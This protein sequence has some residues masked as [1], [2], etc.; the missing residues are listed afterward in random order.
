MI[1]I[2][3][4]SKGL[5]YSTHQI[6]IDDKERAIKCIESV[7]QMYDYSLNSLDVYLLIR[8]LGF[9]AVD[10]FIIR[11]VSEE[12]I[13]VYDSEHI[14]LIDI[15]E[16]LAL[17]ELD[18]DEE[19]LKRIASDLYEYTFS[20]SLMPGEGIYDGQK[21][22]LPHKHSTYLEF[23]IA[24]YFIRKVEEYT[25]DDSID[26]FDTM[27]TSMSNHF[28]VSYMEDNYVFQEKLLKFI[29]DKF[30]LFDVQQKS[31]A[32][33]WL[34]RITYKNLTNEAILFLTKEFTKY[35]LLVKGNN[36]NTQENLD[37]H[38]MFRSICAGLLY[39]GQANYMDE[40]LCIVITNDIANSL[41]R[42][43]TIEYY[44]DSYQMAAHDVYY[45]DTDLSAGET[46]IRVLNSKLENALNS[47]SGEFVEA[48]LVT[49]LTLI[50]A[51]IQNVHTALKYDV[52]SY[53]QKALGFVKMYQ[54]RPQNV[55]SGKLLG[56]FESVREDIELYLNTEKFDIGSVIYRQYNCLKFVK[57]KQWVSK[58]I[59]DPESVTEHT[60]SSW[61]LAAF[62]L[63][64][65]DN[66][67]G[68]N[69]KEIMD[70]LLIHDMAEAVMG[71]RTIEL[72]EPKN[73]IKEEDEI[74]RKLFLKGTYP[75][76]A[77]LTYFYN[78]WTGYYNAVNI[79]AR[80]ARDV[81]LLQ[82]VYTFFEY[83]L[84]YP[85]KFTQSD[86]EKWK[87]EKGNLKTEVGHQLF[88]RLIENNPTFS[89]LF[90]E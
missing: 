12:M 55:V 68:Y 51:R 61:L 8:K 57:R 1:P 28:V 74:L 63:P 83:Y 60:Y 58:G 34:G 54:T 67:D 89:K 18:G 76:I 36:K 53:A 33:Y 79:N 47:H 15:Y 88:E 44:G 32:F 50:Q 10:V 43:A 6:P 42:G 9:I 59:E 49:L 56:Y 52:R 69:K 73:D 35:K 20:Q 65:E 38:F 7:L 72:T 31:N 25:D 84:L 2:V 45:L 19:Q 71:D 23:M 37:N 3:G 39:H 4:D 62:F 30:E 11:L 85:D 77:N 13:S 86:L 90:V 87:Q 78:I 21:W 64:E 66:H 48:N 81:N 17:S 41:N 46:A 70:M 24:Y 26:F 14:R 75:D 40:F 80:T 22:K 5:I 82:S 16:K 29:N 27:L